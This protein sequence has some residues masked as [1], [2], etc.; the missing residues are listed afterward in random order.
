MSQ[1]ERPLISAGWDDLDF[2]D[3]TNNDLIDAGVENVEHR[4]IVSISMH[5]MLVYTNCYVCK[6]NAARDMKYQ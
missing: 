6:Q 2:L 3:F 4:K 1:Y 5:V